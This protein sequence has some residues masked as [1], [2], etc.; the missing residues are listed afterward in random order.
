MIQADIFWTFAIGSSFAAAA[1]KGLKREPRPFAN[2]YFL[3]TLIFPSKT[4]SRR[5]E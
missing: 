4:F 1:S 2:R 3:K 5:F